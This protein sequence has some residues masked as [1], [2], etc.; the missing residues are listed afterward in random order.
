MRRDRELSVL[1][2]TICCVSIRQRVYPSVEQIAVMQMHFAHARYVYNL[3]LEHREMRYSGRRAATS[4]ALQM[5]ELTEAR[6]EFEWLAEGSS[7]VQQVA[8]RDL[9]RAYANF[10]NHRA[11]F[12]TF[13]SKSDPRQSFAI[14]D[15]R[16]RRLNG[17]WVAIT[18]PKAGQVKFRCSRPWPQ[19]CQAT[20][21]R[22]SRHNGQWHVSLTTPPPGKINEDAAAE[23]IGIDRGVAHTLATSSGEFFQ[24]PSW[25]A[26]EQRRFLALQRKL[27]RQRKGSKRRQRTVAKLRTLHRR[28][29]DR[30]REW[31]EQTTTE[32]A[33]RHPVVVLEE[34][35]VSNMVRAPKPKPDPDRDGHWLA[36]GRSAKAKLN[37]AINASLWG[38]LAQRLSDKT[39]VV[40]VNARFTSQ[41]CHRCGHTAPENRK[42]QAVFRCVRCGSTGNADVH[43]A[44]NVHDRGFAP[45]S[46]AA[47]GR[48]VN[49][50]RHKAS[51]SVAA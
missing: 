39:D 35:P 8:L 10:F 29:G 48:A 46:T 15:V 34:L 20:S 33:V 41:C 43:A 1:G 21:A 36:N 47:A 38:E 17:K 19:V 28:L 14:R 3:G 24:A 7:S 42:S 37:K 12:P 27:S 45:L 22:I 44:M 5:R 4:S 13:R 30:R 6:R 23:T 9:D 2:G 26:G 32:L 11:E 31:V 40:K 25:T 51:T 18:V 50:R 49:G 16:L